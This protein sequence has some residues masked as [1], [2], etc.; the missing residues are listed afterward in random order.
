MRILKMYLKQLIFKSKRVLQP[1]LSL[2]VLSNCISD[3]L[4]FDTA[5]L[6]DCT[7]F[8]SIFSDDWIGNLMQISKMCFKQSFSYSKWVLQGSLFLT[9]LSNFVF[10]SSN[11]DIAFLSDC[12]KFYSIFSVY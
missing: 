8:F 11:F 9:V 2:T 3:S 5:F 7:K 12:T 10:G 1:S 4:N 6:A